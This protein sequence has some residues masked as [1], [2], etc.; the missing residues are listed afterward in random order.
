MCLTRTTLFHKASVRPGRRLFP[1]L[2]ALL[3]AL[4]LLMLNACGEAADTSG[5][6]GSYVLTHA[7]ENGVALSA[8]QTAEIALRLRLDPDGGG[9][10][11]SAD[12]SEGSLQWSMDGD[13]LTVQI[14]S[15]RL[16]GTAGSGTLLL[17]SRSETLALRFQAEGDA[18][19]ERAEDSASGASRAEIVTE[20]AG[21]GAPGAQDAEG[22]SAPG[23]PGPD[24][25]AALPR[26]WYGWWKIEESAG[27]LP[28]T[29]YDC[30]AELCPLEGREGL[31]RFLLWDEDGSRSEPMGE[32]LLEADGGGSLRSVSGYFLYQPVQ[33]GEWLLPAEG[34]EILLADLRHDAGGES[35]RYSVYLRPWGADWSDL[36]E[37]QLPFY[38]EDWYLVLKDGRLPMPDAI[39]WEELEAAR[40]GA[41]KSGL[42][43]NGEPT[44]DAGGEQNPD[45]SG[46]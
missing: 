37:E 11:F 35:F 7:E 24:A 43:G 20:G 8:A 46:S 5:L 14:G 18:A 45:V 2:P 28:V 12:G 38:Y 42:D 16:S 6:S 33:E 29:W 23:A 32:V 13:E 17:R 27:A 22:S 19:S 26:D 36:S 10:V 34:D 39:P 15:T 1:A 31:F 4:S 30:C 3:L 25:D 9:A 41:G 21:S 40:E 44:P